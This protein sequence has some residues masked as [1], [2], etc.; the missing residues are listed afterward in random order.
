MNERFIAKR[1]LSVMWLAIAAAISSIVVGQE[2]QAADSI[3]WKFWADAKVI[4]FRPG[5]TLASY[6]WNGGSGGVGPGGTLTL[7]SRD[8]ERRFEVK[9]VGKLKSQRFI[10]SVS[11]KPEEGDS[12]TKSQEI[13]YDL[14]D[15]TPRML[16]IARDEDGRIIQFSLV[17][18]IRDVPQPRQFKAADLR[19]ENWTFAASPLILNDQDYLGQ[20]SMSQSPVAYCDIPGL[21]K[22]EFSLLRLKDALPLGT[23][24]RG[25]IN[26]KHENGTTLRISD[27]KNGGN[28]EVLGGGPY[29]VWVRWLK[30]SETI[31][32]YRESLKRHL[33]TLKERIQN[34]D[35]T[36]SPRH[37]EQLEKMSQSGRVDVSEFGIRGVE[38]GELVEE[39]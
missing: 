16:E 37:L 15:L 34:G 25:V 3:A 12:L 19:L 36:V 18:S 11:V 24:E 2:P 9:I 38:D 20:M 5:E 39:K 22:I 31:E 7:G 17:P 29:R 32:E 35:L 23:L 28:R 33:A 13:E 6:R 30:P 10:A 1:C 14:S 27:V 21:A 8:G 26:I 4:S